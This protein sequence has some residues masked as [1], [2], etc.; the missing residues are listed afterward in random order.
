MENKCAATQQEDAFSGLKVLVISRAMMNEQLRGRAGKLGEHVSTK[1]KK[2]IVKI[3]KDAKKYLES[4]NEA[5]RVLRESEI[6]W[7]EICNPAAPFWER[8]IMQKEFDILREIMNKRRAEEELQL[9][10]LNNYATSRCRALELAII[11]ESRG[12]GWRW[13][14]VRSADIVAL[15]SPDVTISSAEND[16]NITFEDEYDE[17]E[18]FVMGYEEWEN[19]LIESD[20]DEEDV[21]DDNSSIN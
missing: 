3:G 6:T 2:S 8:T 20:S 1:V 10:E 18:H 5:S 12:N 14:R 11:Q 7:E 16:T 21:N 19:N 9:A 13:I 4:Y 15:E 17:E